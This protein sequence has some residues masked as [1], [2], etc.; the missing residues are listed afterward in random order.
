MLEGLADRA[1]DGSYFGAGGLTIV[2][3]RAFPAAAASI[4]QR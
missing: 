4:T 2:E 1:K 3:R